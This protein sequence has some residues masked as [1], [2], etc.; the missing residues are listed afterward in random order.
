MVDDVR[1][2]LNVVSGR[3]WRGI[4]HDQRLAAQTDSPGQT[5]GGRLEHLLAN[6]GQLLE[7]GFGVDIDRRDCRTGQDVV[8]LI[9]ENQSP[10]LFQPFTGVGCPQQRSSASRV[11]LGSVIQTLR[12][13][14]AQFLA[15][16]AGVRPTVVFE[17]QLAVPDRHVGLLRQVAIETFEELARAAHLDPRKARQVLQPTTGFDHLNRRT[18]TT[19][20]VAKSNQALLLE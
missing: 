7:V 15:R 17:I 10:A 19:I 12:Q 1:R 6:S 9:G 20:A 8:E 5:T 11:Q 16:L 3:K 13:R 14:V 18:T 4:E 2:K